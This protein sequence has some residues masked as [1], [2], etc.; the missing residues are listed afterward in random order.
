[1]LISKTYWIYKRW[2]GYNCWFCTIQQCGYLFESH[3]VR[4][5]ITFSLIIV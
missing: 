3:Y 4:N 5:F 1:M 2:I